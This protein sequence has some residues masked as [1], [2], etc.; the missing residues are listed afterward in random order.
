MKKTFFLSCLYILIAITVRAQNLIG[1]WKGTLKV[2]GQSI[3]LVF[4]FSQNNNIWSATM[5]SPAQDAIGIPVSS[6]VVNGDSV[7]LQINAA[8]ISYTGK[9]GT[10]SA[11]IDGIFQQ[12]GMQFPLQLQKSTTEAAMP[13]RPQT[14]KPPFPY[15]T[16]DIQFQNP[17][18]GNTLAGTLTLPKENKNN[19]TCIV[20]VTGSGPQ[21]RDEEMLGHRPFAVL[22]DF[23]TRNGYA[24]LRY[25]DR[26]IGQSTGD[27][28][29]ATIDSFATDAFAAV[30]YLK[31]RKDIRKIGLL[32]HSEGGQIIT[33][34]ATTQQKNIA[35]MI[36]MAGPG[37]RGDSMLLLQTNAIMQKDGFS[38]SLKNTAQIVNRNIYQ[39]V[40]QNK[41]RDTGITKILAYYHSIHPKTST[42]E[43]EKL[44]AQFSPEIYSLLSFDPALYLQKINI[45]ILAINGSED[46]QVLPK[47]NLDGIRKATLHNKKVTI[48]ELPGLNHLFQQC[49]SCTV[50]E[51]GELEQTISPTA[52]DAI[53]AWLNKTIR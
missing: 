44:K 51:Y 14:P 47:E 15:M 22:A 20:L 7:L 26:G 37:L 45:P 52:L 29:T 27:Y 43:L 34:L 33:Q 39:I 28:Q 11:M 19:Y 12:N 8:N 38:D 46:I 31:T 48:Q 2:G 24:V 6:V 41:N 17:V 53:L 23:L 30:N 5:D 36:M 21:N 50:T 32:G 16:E 49:K 42:Q 4:H 9:Y 18:S 13:N 1:Q 35:F 10:R 3:P 25:D 40:L